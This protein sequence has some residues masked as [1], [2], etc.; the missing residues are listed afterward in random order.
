MEAKI[1]RQVNIMFAFDETGRVIDGTKS[2]TTDS[3][4][5]ITEKDSRF[6]GVTF[7]DEHGMK[8]TKDGKSPVIGVPFEKLTDEQKNKFFQLI[9]DY[10]ALKDVV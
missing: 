4:E 2:I 3:G 1:T 7:F 5:V 8:S 9:A 6:V 10:E